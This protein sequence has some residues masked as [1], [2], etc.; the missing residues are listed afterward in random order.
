[1][2]GLP[3]ASLSNE[4]FKKCLDLTESLK[5]KGMIK[6]LQRQVPIEMSAYRDL[7]FWDENGMANYSKLLS[8]MKS[9]MAKMEDDEIKNKVFS[10]LCIG[11]W[12][13]YIN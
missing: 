1:L 3:I 9:V 12:H 7:K 6:I 4:L 8:A 13:A 2:I 10:I 11:S 5:F